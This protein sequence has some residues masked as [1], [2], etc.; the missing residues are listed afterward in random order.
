MSLPQVILR[1]HAQLPHCTVP[2][3]PSA[4]FTCQVKSHPTAS[5]IQEKGLGQRELPHF[6]LFILFYLL[7]SFPNASLM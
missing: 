4:T 7:I 5:W 1:T 2:Y 3:D 6:F